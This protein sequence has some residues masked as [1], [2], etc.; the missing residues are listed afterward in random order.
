MDTATAKKHIAEINAELVKRATSRNTQVIRLV[1]DVFFISPVLI[2]AGARKSDLP[3]WLRIAV[4]GIGIATLYY[5]M[6]NFIQV[7]KII[8]DI[9]K[10]EEKI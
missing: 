8:S 4:A 7:E 3:T 1:G 5:N 9:K 10:L 2:Y 6:K